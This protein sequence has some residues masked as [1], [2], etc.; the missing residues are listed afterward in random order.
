MNSTTRQKYMDA[1][2]R[3]AD[4]IAQADSAFAEN[5]IE[6]GKDLTAQ[7]AA[8]NP[9]IEGYQA[10][11]EQEGKFAGAKAPAVDPAVKDRAE[12]R[13]ETLRNGGRIT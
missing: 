8:L 6:K 13:A 4:L 1:L 5:N 7:A 12:E 9:E 3:R 10:L 11:L 2:N